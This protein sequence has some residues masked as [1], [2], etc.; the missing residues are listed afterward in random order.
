MKRSILCRR[1]KC[2][3]FDGSI[4]RSA[5]T[6]VPV[7]ADAYLRKLEPVLQQLQKDIPEAKYDKKGLAQLVAQLLQFMEVALGI[8]VSPAFSFLY[9]RC[10]TSW[11]SDYIHS[12][13]GHVW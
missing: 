1:D 10:D 6:S 2:S 3:L 4:S 12:T 13:P 9:S 5:D 11:A 7:Q 8:N